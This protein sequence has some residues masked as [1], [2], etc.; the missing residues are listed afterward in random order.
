MFSALWESTRVE[1]ILASKSSP[2]A[3]SYAHRDDSLFNVAQTMLKQHISALPILDTHNKCVGIIDIKDVMILLVRKL[4]EI[5]DWAS[6]SSAQFEQFMQE[7]PAGQVMDP[8]RGD[9]L[10]LTHAKAP[11]KQVIRF[12]ASG[13]AH[14]CVVHVDED[15]F[16]V[17]SQIDVANF[18]GKAFS[19]ETP[20]DAQKK[21]RDNLEAVQLMEHLR[22]RSVEA[23]HVVSCRENDLVIDAVKKL[24][25]EEVSALAVVDENNKLLANFSLA[26]ILHLE[27]ASFTDLNLSVGQF[28]KKY[29]R[30]SYTP[31]A[32]QKNDGTL[33]DVV[34]LISALGI[35]R[36]WVVDSSAYE[37]FSPIAVVT[38]TDVFSILQ[39]LNL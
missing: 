4:D 27:F 5:S 22:N 38:L 28:L 18:L 13:L 16:E 30:W 31:M 23:H 29:S 32:L 6:W 20:N 35:H 39:H 8:S 3:F 33:A 14:R 12:F 7:I 9:P 10:I 2:H 17:L 21:I 36:L 15:K 25:H 11:M 24:F 34:V 37:H 26:D 1:E 19:E